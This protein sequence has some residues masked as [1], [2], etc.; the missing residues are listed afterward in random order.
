MSNLVSSSARTGSETQLYPALE[1]LA[2]GVGYRLMNAFPMLL[3]M[4]AGILLQATP[5]P[6]LPSAFAGN[7]F[8]APSHWK[9]TLGYMLGLVEAPIILGFTICGVVKP[10]PKGSAEKSPVRLATDGIN[11]VKVMP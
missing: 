5:C 6:W 2:F 11:P 4:P 8:P 10:L 1:L 9:Y 3:N 7:G